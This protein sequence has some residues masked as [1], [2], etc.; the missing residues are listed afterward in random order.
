MANKILKGT[1]EDHLGNTLLPETL[2]IQVKTADGKTVEVKLAELVEK[3]TALVSKDQAL[4]AKDAE[5]LAKFAQYLPTSGGAINGS[6]QISGGA[7]LN[8]S[9]WGGISAGPDGA[10]LIGQNCYKDSKTNKYHFTN[11]H[12]NMGARGIIF[13]LGW[14]D[15]YIFDTGSRATTAGEEFTPALYKILTEKGGNIAGLTVTGNGSNNLSLV[16]TDHV[17]MQIYRTGIA[18]GRSAYIGYGG[19]GDPDVTVANTIS[20]GAVKIISA[21]G[22]TVNG[23]KVPKILRSTAAPTASDGEDGDVWHQYV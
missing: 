21:G 1:L 14:K 6:L 2:A 18:G 10:V 4:D 7:G 22:L 12:G 16:G 11:T 3:I 13:L 19:V 17:Y 9:T 23:T 15:A 8:L 20:G 5:L